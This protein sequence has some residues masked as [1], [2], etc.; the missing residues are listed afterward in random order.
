MSVYFG[1]ELGGGDGVVAAPDDDFGFLWRAFFKGPDRSCSGIDNYNPVDAPTGVKAA[2]AQD[3]E[4]GIFGGEDF[5]DYFE[6]LSWVGIADAAFGGDYVRDRLVCGI[7]FESDFLSRL[8]A[9]SVEH[10]NKNLL[11]QAV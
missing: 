2:L 1:P 7:E 10:S 6:R 4:E 8:V 5:D 3:A 9:E 11:N